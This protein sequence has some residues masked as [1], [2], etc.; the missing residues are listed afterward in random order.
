MGC[1]ATSV[2]NCL[3]RL[4]NIPEY[5]I[6]TAAETRIS[7]IT[8]LKVLECKQNFYRC[9]YVFWTRSGDRE[10]HFS[11]FIASQSGTNI[12]MCRTNCCVYFQRRRNVLK[13]PKSFGV[14]HHVDCTRSNTLWKSLMDRKGGSCLAGNTAWR[15]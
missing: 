1:S 7:I 15:L 13:C 4:P 6:Y 14:T 8:F 5:L 10:G 11:E 2:T 3:S 9:C 12:S